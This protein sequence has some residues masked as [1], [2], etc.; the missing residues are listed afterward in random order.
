MI[1]KSKTLMMMDDSE[2]FY[3]IKKIEFGDISE[4]TQK[5]LMLFVATFTC[6]PYG[7]LF[8]GQDKI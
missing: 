1:R 8:I 5:K 3:K 6:D 2:I 7:Y 4:K